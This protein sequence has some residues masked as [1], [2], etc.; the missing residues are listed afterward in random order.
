MTFHSFGFSR[1]QSGQRQLFSRIGCLVLSFL[2]VSSAS[3]TQLT[4]WNFKDATGAEPD[5]LATDVAAGFQHTLITRGPTLLSHDV[6]APRAGTFWNGAWPNGTGL[7]QYFE[8]SI[9]S[10]GNYSISDIFFSFYTDPLGPHQWHLY[11]NNAE[12]N[13]WTDAWINGP[14]GPD[15]THTATLDSAFQ[16]LSGTTTFRL[17]GN[18]GTGAGAGLKELSINGS[19]SVPETLPVGVFGLTA[20]VLFFI[21]SRVRD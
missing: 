20:A 3:A 19:T 2:L 4:A 15:S 1:R 6:G 8:F 16:N 12:I 11:F 13:N 10:A 18:N 21:R 7:D 17:Y 14:P 5:Y 9:N